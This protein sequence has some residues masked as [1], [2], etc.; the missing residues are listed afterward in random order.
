M[1][2]DSYSAYYDGIVEPVLKFFCAKNAELVLKPNRKDAIWTEYC[3]LNE[4]CKH[5]YMRDRDHLIDRHKVVACYMYAI[6]RAHVVS[7]IISLKEG[8]DTNLMLNER[9]AFSFGMSMLRA[10][11]LAQADNLEDEEQR[12]KVKAAFDSGISFPECNHGDYADN[13]RSQLY[14]THKEGNYNI[15]SMAETLYFIEVF[16][17]MKHGLP[18]DVFRKAV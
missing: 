9:L 17:L 7:S 5:R 6:E 3:A 2:C 8:D 4:Q 15:L 13:L 11:I 18:V 12:T 16:N 1:D 14:F 10:L